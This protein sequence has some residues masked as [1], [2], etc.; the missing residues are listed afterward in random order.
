M[1]LKICGNKCSF[2]YYLFI[3]CWR[4]PARTALQLVPCSCATDNRRRLWSLSGRWVSPLPSAREPRTSAHIAAWFV[5]L[6][7]TAAH[8]SAM[9]PLCPLPCCRRPSH[10]RPNPFSHRSQSNRRR[11]DSGWATIRP[12]MSVSS[13]A[14]AP[15]LDGAAGCRHAQLQLYGTLPHPATR[16]WKTYS[17]AVRAIPLSVCHHGPPNGYR[18]GFKRCSGG[19]QFIQ[20]TVVNDINAKAVEAWK[21]IR[22]IDNDMYTLILLTRYGIYFWHEL[23]YTLPHF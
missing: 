15:L 17:M 14:S 8:P 10:S 1:S 9:A 18:T 23:A 13:S 21:Q 12:P 11:A 19:Q 3:I 6:K 2:I 20:L 5:G 4:V 16:P 7:K 22:S